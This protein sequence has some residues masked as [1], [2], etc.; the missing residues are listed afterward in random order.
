MKIKV[1]NIVYDTESDGEVHDIDLP[2]EMILD[3]P[4]DCDIEDEIA[5]EISNKTGWCIEFFNY[6]IL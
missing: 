1:T 6:E 4:N 5:N 2:K 3:I